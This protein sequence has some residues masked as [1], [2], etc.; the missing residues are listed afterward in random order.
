MNI[1]NNPFV[2]RQTESSPFSYYA[3]DMEDVPALVAANFKNRTQGY[4]DGVVIV[5]VSP[6]GFYTGVVTLVEGSTLTGSYKA[7]RDGEQPRKQVL[8]QGAQKIP[9]AKVDVVLYRSDVL[10][11]GNDNTLE[12]SEDNWEI[13]SINAAPIDTDMP[14]DPMTLMHN[15]FGSDGGTD[16]N[17]SD[18][19][20]VSLLRAGFEFWKDKAMCG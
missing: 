4:R 14:I 17:M 7:R 9:A 15:H 3:G 12:P 5:P 2:M 10:A 13:I 16:T 11:E 8:A 6:K 1:I 20:F 18:E 19:E